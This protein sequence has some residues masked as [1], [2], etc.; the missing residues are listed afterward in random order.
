MMR[1]IKITSIFLGL[2]WSGSSV[3]LAAQDGDYLLIDDFTSDSSVFG[4]FWEGFTDRVMGGRSDIS[5]GVVKEG[6]EAFMRMRGRVSLENNGGFIQVRL[7]FAERRGFFDASAYRGVRIR[8]R[9]IGDNYYIHLRTVK[10]VFPWKYY[11]APLPVGSEWADIEL[12][13]T[14]FTGGDYGRL[15]GLTVDK[16]KSI[17]ITASKAEFDADI[18]ISE[19]GLYR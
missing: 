10:T 18:E 5:A 9:G 4:T 2:L 19:I 13:W 7:K 14:L 17:A 8:A 1:T 3:P 12:P 16:L 6:D 11:S 15:P